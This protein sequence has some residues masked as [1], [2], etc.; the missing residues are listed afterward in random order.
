MNHLLISA[1]ALTAAALGVLPAHA[2]QPT[3]PTGTIKNIVLVR[4]LR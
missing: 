1:I 2:A 4:C 3:L